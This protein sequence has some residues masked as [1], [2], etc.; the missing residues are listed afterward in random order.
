[1]MNITDGIPTMNENKMIAEIAFAQN[2]AYRAYS[3]KVP[4]H[5]SET[6]LK[7]KDAEKIS[8]ILSKKVGI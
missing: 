1:M 3:P 6:V 5:I 8:E 2:G 4:F 7:I